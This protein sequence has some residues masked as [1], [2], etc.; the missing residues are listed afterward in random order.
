MS[1][2]KLPDEWCKQYGFEIYDPDGWR[3]GTDKYK[4]C[5]MD[6][7]ITNEEFL[8]RAAISTI[9]DLTK[10]PLCTEPLYT[11]KESMTKLFE[12][13]KSVVVV[14]GKQ[15]VLTSSDEVLELLK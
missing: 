15:R 13:D 8:A 1:A 3:S 4:P 6:L 11:M 10:F 7:P 12:I 5:S 2:E 14:T 9:S